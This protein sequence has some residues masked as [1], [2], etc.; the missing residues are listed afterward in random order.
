M[1]NFM[2]HSVNLLTLTRGEDTSRNYHRSCS[3]IVI[4]MIIT[5][6]ASLDQVTWLFGIMQG[7]NKGKTTL[8][9]PSV[10]AGRS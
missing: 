7:R 5:S 3:G 10:T 4:I 6:G 8:T 1:S 9:A 2:H